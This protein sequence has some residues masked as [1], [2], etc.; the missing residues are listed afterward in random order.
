MQQFLKVFY[1]KTRLS[2][3]LLSYMELLENMFSTILGMKNSNKVK[4][5]LKKSAKDSPL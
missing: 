5:N 4:K 2:Q 3:G 1:A